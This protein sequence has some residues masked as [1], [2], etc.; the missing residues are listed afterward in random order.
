MRGAGSLEAWEAAWPGACGV[1]PRLVSGVRA[2]VHHYR[3]EPWTVVEHEAT[4]R[5]C[6]LSADAARVIELLDGRRTLAALH[7]ELCDAL[8]AEAAP[9]RG[10]LLRL[11]AQLQQLDLLRSDA[12]AEIGPLCERLERQDGAR[13]AQRWRSLL[14]IRIPLWDPTPLL[15]RGMPLARRLSGPLA[16][17]A[18]GVLVGL[19]LLAALVEAPALAEHARERALAPSNLLLVWLLFPLVKALHEL[20]HAFACRLYGGAVHETGLTLLVLTPVPYVDASSSAVFPE[21]R[22]RVAVAAAGVAVELALGALAFWLWLLLEPGRLRDVCFDVALIATVSTLAFNGNPLLRFDAYYVLADLLEMPNLASRASRLLGYGLRRHAFGLTDAAPPPT[23]PGE[24]PWLVAYGLAAWVYKLFVVCAIALF[25]AGHFFVFGVALALW[26]LAAQVVWPLARQLD[27]V[28]R[29]P[30]LAGRRGRPLAVCAAIAGG[31]VIGL[32]GVP[33]P[34]ATVS[35]GV[36][37]LPE[38]ARIRAAADGFVVAVL[39]PDG[40]LVEAGEPLFETDAPELRSRV[41]SLR[42]AVRDLEIQRV[43][44][45]IGDRLA[46]RLLADEL[47]ERRA[48]L[49][50]AE[51]Q[52]ASLR[53]GSPFAGRFVVPGVQHLPGRFARQGDT[54]GYVIADAP[55]IVRVAVPESAMGHVRERTRA[56]EAR[57]PQWPGRT[58]RAVVE[59][60]LPR[61]SDRLPSPALGTRGGGHLEVDAADASRSRAP[62][63]QLDLALIEPEAPLFAGSRVHVRFV[64]APEPVGPRLLRRARQLFLTQLGV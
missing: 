14:A 23:A 57:V 26:A 10:E 37:R 28:L 50:E 36:L 7:D 13:R 12:A 17:T 63:Y 58:L 56:V 5:R 22:K 6:R 46:A 20:G 43:D 8:G 33:L 47:R 21:K 55:P 9:S 30:S 45:M 16:C 32:F 24:R 59:R 49:A 4:G 48:E 19:A 34:S 25:L 15:D 2:Q 29:D 44:Q 35:E 60:E 40:G 11:I 61:A 52:L 1:A 64:H 54:L 38:Q 51:R 53:I 39:A 31:L 41:E 27:G 62:V 42:W 3:G 18:W